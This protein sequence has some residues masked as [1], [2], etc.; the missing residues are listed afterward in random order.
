MFSGII[1][2][3]KP[4]KKAV[5]NENSWTV[6]IQRPKHFDDIKFGDSICCNGVCLT[7][8]SFDAETMVFTLAQETIQVLKWSNKSDVQFDEKLK[9]PW[10]LER[11]LR[12]S[13]RIHGQILSGH[14]WGIGQVVETQKDADGLFLKINIPIKIRKFIWP[15]SSLAIHGV[16]LTVNAVK[17]LDD[18]SEFV[19][20][21][22]VY[23]IP[24]TIQQTNLAFLRIGD[25][26]NL[27]P[28]YLAVALIESRN[29]A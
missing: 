20:S 6:Y 4:V 2:A 26:V 27:E 5:Q 22:E 24:A 16:S 11:S 14:V 15:K 17:D 21:V 7:L 10:N 13:D 23:L 8:E 28:D 3:C 12:L 18:V 29:H 1:E 25:W 9:T 19:A